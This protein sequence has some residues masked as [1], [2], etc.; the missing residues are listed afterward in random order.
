MEVRAKKS[1]ESGASIFIGTKLVTQIKYK[2][3]NRCSNNQAEHLAILKALEAV[4]TISP[5]ES[6]ARKATVYTE[7]R[8]TIDSL[9]NPDNHAHLI[10]EIRRR[11][12]KLQSSNWKIGFSWVKSHA[13][14]YGNE[15]ADKLAKEA[16]RSKHTEISFRRIPISTLA[17]GMGN[18]Q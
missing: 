10:E 2:L 1:L 16:A 13:G 12:A 7:S 9:R 11:V 18:L 17:K 6:R 14:N 3:D 15:L 4:D 8:L 5:E